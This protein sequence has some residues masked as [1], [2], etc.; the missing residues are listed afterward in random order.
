MREKGE[1]ELKKMEAAKVNNYSHNFCSGKNRN[2]AGDRQGVKGNLFFFSFLRW[3]VLWCIC[4]AKE[5]IQRERGNVVIQKEE[6]MVGKA[7][8]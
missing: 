4:M 6:G 3:Y 8:F 2:V 5:I 1:W 7:K